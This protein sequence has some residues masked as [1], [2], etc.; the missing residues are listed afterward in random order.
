MSRGSEF[1]CLVCGHKEHYRIRRRGWQRWLFPRG[2]RYR[3]AWC[4][5]VSFQPFGGGKR[6]NRRG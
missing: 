5:K 2:R 6:R 3:C 4:G 1:P